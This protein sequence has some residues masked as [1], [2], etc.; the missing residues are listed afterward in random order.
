LDGVLEEFI[1]KAKNMKG[2]ENA[3]RSAEKGRALG[4]GCVSKGSKIE[5]IDSVEI[6]GINYNLEDF[7]ELNGEKIKV[8]TLIKTIE[9]D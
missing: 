2:F 4:L 5:V 6:D 3:V 1:Q 7:I 8:S 9:I